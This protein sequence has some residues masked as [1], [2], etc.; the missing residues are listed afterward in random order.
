MTTI[1]DA[2]ERIVQ[3]FAD[4]KVDLDSRKIESDM[5]NLV[6]NFGMSMQEAERTILA[7]ESRERNVT[8]YEG[9]HKGN[10]SMRD[11]ASLKDKEWVTIEGMITKLMEPQAKSIHQLGVI[12]DRSGDIRFTVWA[13]KKGSTL[14]PDLK[15]GH[16]YRISN[17][18]VDTY[19]GALNLRVHSS[20][21]V[22]DVG[23]HGD[24]KPVI[25]LIKDIKP[26]IVNVKGKVT[27]LFQNTSEKIFQTG[28]IGDSSG[29]T[30]FTIW[31][32]DNPAFK[33]QEGKS[34]AFMYAQGVE[35]KGN[36]NLVASTAIKEIYEDIQVKTS[37][38]SF[39]GNVVQ[40]RTGSGLVRRCPVAG[41]GRVL[42][43]QSYCQVH[44]IQKDFI[45]DMRVKGVLDDGEKALNIHVPL[46]VI[47]EI[48]G[49]TLGE[50]IATAEKSPMGFEDILSSIKNKMLGRYFIIDGTEYPD[51]I[52]VSKMTPIRPSMDDAKELMKV[53]A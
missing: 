43:K 7:R 2:T 13:R 46:R 23:D 29:T 1:K 30:K 39:R 5:T 44:E 27:R 20:T 15:V 48:T 19:M 35:Y 21:D 32:S 8:F 6:K 22:Q 53:L 52:Y 24:V 47:E 9:L 33:L 17:G 4:K 42:T 10:S 50:A 41:C 36:M 37:T 49:I 11:I 34:Y 38:A 45:Y 14:P 26:G 31:A 18:T 40:I 28:I 12:S 16:W 51:R 3:R 25:T